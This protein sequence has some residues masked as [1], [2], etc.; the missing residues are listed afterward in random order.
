[1]FFKEFEISLIKEWGSAFVLK[2]VILNISFNFYLTCSCLSKNNAI[3][4]FT[5]TGK[6]KNKK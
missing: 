3:T 6:L 2:M 5:N 4:V 1:M